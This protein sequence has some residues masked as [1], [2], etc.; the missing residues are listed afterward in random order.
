LDPDEVQRIG[1]GPLVRE[2][3]AKVSKEKDDVD[4]YHGDVTQQDI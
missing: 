3:L 2:A 1:T 4:T